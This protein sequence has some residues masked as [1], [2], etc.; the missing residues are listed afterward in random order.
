MTT[1]KTAL[2]TDLDN[3]LFDW[4]ELWLNC[5][6]AM[7]DGIV[8][9]SGISREILIPEIAAVHQKHGPGWCAESRLLSSRSC[10]PRGPVRPGP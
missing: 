2:I 6:S 5:F 3:T 8:E 4:V 7:L 9:V 10:A 1:R